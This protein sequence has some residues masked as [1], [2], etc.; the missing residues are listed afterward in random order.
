MIFPFSNRHTFRDPFDPARQIDRE[1]ADRSRRLAIGLSLEAD[2][3]T[4]SGA[5]I[6]VEGKGKYLHVLHAHSCCRKLPETATGI[7]TKLAS[8]SEPSWLDIKAVRSDIAQVQI[9]LVDELK[10][11]AGKYVDRLLI[12]AISDPGLWIA[13]GEPVGSYFPICDPNPIADVTGISIVDSF[14]NRDI[15]AGGTGRQLHPL[16]VWI[17]LADRARIQASQNRILFSINES[18]DA[19]FLPASD[20]LDVEIPKIRFASCSGLSRFRQIL[21]NCQ[22]DTIPQ[23][24]QRLNVDGKFNPEIADDLNVDDLLQVAA[25]RSISLSDCVRT[26]IVQM[27]NMISDQIIVQ[28]GDAGP[29]PQVVVDCVPDLLGTFVNQFRRRWPNAQGLGKFFDGSEAGRL[30]AILTG[31]LGVMGIDQLPANIPWITGANAQRTLGR[32]T[33]GAPSNWRQL[34]KEMADF[35]PPAMRLRDA[36]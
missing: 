11:H 23:R 2:W 29:N 8:N 33:P 10:R 31:I 22:P 9:E 17:L 24:I 30:S 6:A 20:G 16:P 35:Q 32:F 5:L 21:S 12:V 13:D 36:V 4:V 27:V 15:A 25:E 3:R 1:V 7:L 34:L 14:P 18:A 26:L 19:Y 28:M